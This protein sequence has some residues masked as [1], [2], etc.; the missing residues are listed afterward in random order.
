MKMK[1]MRY[2]Q[3]A[4]GGG[5]SLNLGTGSFAGLTPALEIPAFAGAGHLAGFLNANAFFTARRT[6]DRSRLWD[7]S[8]LTIYREYQSIMTARYIKLRFIRIYVKSIPKM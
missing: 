4:A 5:R 8:Q 6:N 7:S 2:N 3:S 1:R